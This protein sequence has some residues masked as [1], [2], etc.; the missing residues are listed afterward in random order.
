MIQNNNDTIVATATAR[1]K[2]GVGIVRVSG[3]D[4]SRYMLGLLG[5][6]VEPRVA[7][8]GKFLDSEGSSIDEG[9]VLYFPSPYSF[10]GES[11]LELHG[12]GGVV[13]LDSLVARCVE[14][15]ARIAR[16]GEFSERAFLNDKI[17]LA[18]AEAIADLIDAATVEAA[19]SAVRSMQGDFSNLVSQLVEDT[20]YIRT[21]VE[22]AIDFPEEEV[23]F[24]ND[25]VLLK[26]LSD[27][28]Q[29]LKDL[30]NRAKQ[31][32][33]M[34]DG[35]TIVLA[36]KPNAG[37]SS[38]LN[39]LAENQTAIVTPIAGTTRDVIRDKII[40]QG[41]PVNIIDT[42]G[43]RES[44]DPIEKEGIARAW[45]EIEL[46]D[47]IFFLVDSTVDHEHD[48]RKVWPEFYE[49][50]PVSKQ[51][52]TVLLN[53]IDVSGLE[54]GMCDSSGNAFAI[55]AKN[56]VGINILIHH[57]HQSVG[58]NTSSEGIFS[59]RRRHLAALEAAQ[60]SVKTGLS[61]LLDSGAGELL[62]EDLRQAQFQLSEITGQ[63]TSD[64][65]LGRIFSSFCIG[66]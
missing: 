13:V 44:D 10:T 19:R 58:F 62:A 36:G 16:P 38:L 31:G 28:E 23:D 21:Y 1:G 49:R 3:I 25:K 54:A 53:K 50:F 9:I 41:L 65:L 66:K 48:L 30:L 34:K 2:G 24:L 29:S 43:L 64:D 46:A 56:K 11:V 40:V 61:Q 59:A 47:H 35:L 14:L 18:Q 17:D 63:F 51:K 52:V 27:L 32:S 7:N 6:L 45:M 33:L 37:K 12:H 22:A 60:S 4:V 26:K 42:A 5:K 55:S 57:L 15:G 39:A 20:I 8:F